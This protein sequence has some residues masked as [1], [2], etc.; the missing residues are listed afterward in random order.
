[1]RKLYIMQG[2]PGVGKSYAIS[3]HRLSR[4]VI[5][6]DAMR[7]VLEPSSEAMTEDG[8]L[9]AA[10]DFSPSNSRAAFAMCETMC[11]A[12]MR[13]GETVILDS[14]A[15]RR[16]TIAR[17]LSLAHRYHY[18]VA[19]VDMQHGL[20]LDEALMRNASRPVKGVPEDVVR[21][22]WE[23][24][25]NYS[26]APGERRVTLDTML[27]EFTTPDI[28]ANPF[29]R[30]VFVADVQG[31]MTE[32]SRA[33]VP[34]YMADP[35]TL[36]VFVGDLLD[37]GPH[38]EAHLVLDLAYRC[39]DARNVIFI[40]GNHDSRLYDFGLGDTSLPKQ[41]R[42]SERDC[43]EHSPDGE[44]GLNA[45]ATAVASSMLPFACIDYG[46]YRF[47]VTHA[48]LHPKRIARHLEV[49]GA[50]SHIDDLSMW[51]LTHG[52]GNRAGVSDYNTD[53]CRVFECEH[54]KFLPDNVI[55]VFGHRHL[56]TTVPGD[57]PHTFGIETGAEFGRGL[58]TL[59]VTADGRISLSNTVEGKLRFVG[60]N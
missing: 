3:R 27:R 26:L 5:S 11:D 24:C 52:D 19:Y 41:T 60:E 56:S 10:Y 55:Q 43:I 15:A 33:G 20:T 46:K 32:L 12:K 37:R 39:H 25:A 6:P 44:K 22:D 1:M 7:H 14:I 2:A 30:I 29:G 17:F 18:E 42:E 51:L 8:S 53:V 23:R 13:R 35:S 57:C 21:V 34:D 50:V 31:C 48:G 45:R 16:K 40:E 28:D 4:H 59:M 49:D 38:D 58:T 36:V 47:F 54:R 9:E